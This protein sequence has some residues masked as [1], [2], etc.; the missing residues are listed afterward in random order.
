MIHVRTRITHVTPEMTGG[1]ELR[2]NCPACGEKGV[3]ANAWVAEETAQ[4]VWTL[5]TNWVQCSACGAT[6]YSRERADR[7]AVASIG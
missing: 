1:R 4:L 5:R 2:I 7:T 6:L 3:L